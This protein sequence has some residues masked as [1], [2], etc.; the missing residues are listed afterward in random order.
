MAPRKDSPPARRAP[1]S[2][3][4]PGVPPKPLTD[5]SIKA[6]PQ[7]DEHA[8]PALRPRQEVQRVDQRCIEGLI[9]AARLARPE[10]SALVREL[11][12]V[13][14]QMTPETRARADRHTFLL[15]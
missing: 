7:D 14:L 15:V 5:N 8:P 6:T 13:L 2:R 10:M 12:E 9:Q 4:R 11:R 1:R 3:A